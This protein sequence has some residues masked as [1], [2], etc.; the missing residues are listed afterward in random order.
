LSTSQ[1]AWIKGL[2][3]LD[4]PGTY[5]SK[6]TKSIDNIPPGRY[7]AG[8]CHDATTG[9]TYIFGGGGASNTFFADL[10]HVSSTGHPCT[11][12]ASFNGST[13]VPCSSGSYKSTIGDQTCN[14][15]PA[16]Q[17][18]PSSGSTVCI[19]C[20]NGTYLPYTGA[21]SQTQCLNCESRSSG[22][23]QTACT[24]TFSQTST[25]PGLRTSTA[26]SL[27]TSRTTLISSAMIL[28]FMSTTIIGPA[29]ISSVEQ[30]TFP[31]QVVTSFEHSSTTSE[32]QH[33]QIQDA[34]SQL[35]ANCTVKANASSS[36]Q[37][38]RGIPVTDSS[39]TTISTSTLVGNN[40][41]AW[42]QVLAYVN[43]NVAVVSLA[44]MSVIG[45]LLSVLLHLCVRLQLFK[46]KQRNARIINRSIWHESQIIR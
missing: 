9:A 3:T 24:A 33:T 29:R 35:E 44:A 40:T 37:G 1:Y 14:P 46:Q 19:S 27:A 8:Y 39:Q 31:Q 16:G 4:S 23:G 7:G 6:N 17:Y 34:N 30:S 36:P 26:D 11:P 10:W 13:C 43:R 25:I 12:G 41:A 15:C 20:P 18:Q 42:S 2:T 32:W 22:A 28:P 5:G 45:L 21:I 38:E